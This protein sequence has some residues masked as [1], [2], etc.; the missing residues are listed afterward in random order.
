MLRFVL[1]AFLVLPFVDLFLLVK[2]AETVG[3]WQTIGIILL[4]GVA[5]AELIRREGRFVLKKLQSSITVEEM[6]RNVMEGFMLLASGLLLLTPGLVTDLI[7]VLLVF[8]PFRE[9]LVVRLA[10]RAKEQGSV[11]VETFSL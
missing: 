8:R 11:R 7:G 6:S 3:F 1:I 5:G 10:R 4:T 2:V 9:R